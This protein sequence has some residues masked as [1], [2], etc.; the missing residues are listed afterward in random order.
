[1]GKRTPETKAPRYPGQGHPWAD[2]LN[3]RARVL[4]MWRREGKTPEACVRDM[5]MDPM[6]VTL[7]LMTVAEHPEEFQ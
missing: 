7:I 5:S 4:E 3:A 1:M 2:F 6:Q